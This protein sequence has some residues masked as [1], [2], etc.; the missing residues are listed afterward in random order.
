MGWLFKN[1]K[2]QHQTPAQYITE[3]FTYESEMSKNTVIAAATVKNTI[4]A[5]IKREIKSTGQVFTFCGVFLYKNNCK[6]GFGYKDIDET[7]GPGEVDC[8]DRIM[9]LLS[10]V[11]DIPNPSYAASWRA[12]V[13]AAKAKR[14]AVRENAKKLKVGDVI[15][16][17]CEPHFK[18]IP[19][20][21][22]TFKVVDFRKTTPIFVPVTH[23]YLRCR[24][25]KNTLVDAMFI[26]GSLAGEPIPAVPNIA[27]E[28]WE[29]L[30]A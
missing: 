12:N 15:R 16:L 25:H 23:P 11:E 13:A 2:L 4:Y 5:A 24:L 29:K 6:D 3:H 27:P 26:E 9:K 20:C 17:T 18:S 7:M 10:P 14:T 30:N 8:P 1:D 19:N 21:G 22:N 28:S